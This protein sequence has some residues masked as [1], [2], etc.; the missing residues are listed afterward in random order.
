MFAERKSIEQQRIGPMNG[1]SSIG[2]IPHVACARMRGNKRLTETCRAEEEK[3]PNQRLHCSVHDRRN[4]D[5]ARREKKSPAT[6]Q[7]RTAWILHA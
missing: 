4:D 1:A 5:F 2:N 7:E 6:L 3:H